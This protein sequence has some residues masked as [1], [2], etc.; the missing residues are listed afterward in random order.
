MFKQFVYELAEEA[1]KLESALAKLTTSR[2][3][4]LLHSAPIDGPSASTEEKLSG[5]NQSRKYV[6]NQ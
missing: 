1:I 2:R 6:V 3:V 5:D 4:V